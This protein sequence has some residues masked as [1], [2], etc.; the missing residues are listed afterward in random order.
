MRRGLIPARPGQDPQPPPEPTHIERLLRGRR[1]SSEIRQ[2]PGRQTCRI[3]PTSRGPGIHAPPLPSPPQ[4]GSRTRNAARRSGPRT[5]RVAPP[6]LSRDD[7]LGIVRM[8]QN[9]E[10]RPH[11]GRQADK[12]RGA[13][14]VGQRDDDPGRRSEHAR[15]P[16]QSPAPRDHLLRSD[17]DALH[18]GRGRH[19]HE[20][21]HRRQEQD[22]N[23]DLEPHRLTPRGAE[24]GLEYPV[25]DEEKRR[26]RR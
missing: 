7:R 6:L 5:T 24:C 10:Q 16:V 22:G 2:V 9:A 23:G 12:Q 3:F 14:A 18:H 20:Q 4:T 8:S 11:V 21:A 19:A 26:R 13:E 17:V 1:T 25:A 15:G